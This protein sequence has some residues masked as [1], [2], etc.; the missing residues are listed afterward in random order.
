MSLEDAVRGV[1]ADGQSLPAEFLDYMIQYQSQNSLSNKTKTPNIFNA[2]EYG[3]TGDG[4]TDDT[5]A[6]QAAI[7]DCANNGGGQVYIPAGTYA[8]KTYLTLG[9]NTALVGH[10]PETTLKLVSGYVSGSQGQGHL[11]ATGASHIT[12]DSITFDGNNGTITHDAAN[13]FAV[14]FLNS[15]HCTVKNCSAT[16]IN[17]QGSNLN[18]AFAWVGTSDFGIAADNRIYSCSGGALFF[19]GASSIAHGNIVSTCG[20]VGIVFNSTTCSRCIA[21][22]N[23]IDEIPNQCAFGV[24]AG[25]S[26]FV[27]TSNTIS[28]CFGALDLND[29]GFA[30]PIQRGGVFANNVISD[31]DKGASS[32]TLTLGVFFRSSWLRNVK[33]IGN[34]FSGLHPYGTTDA[35]IYVSANTQDIEI[36]NNT[37]EDTAQSV[38]TGIIFASGTHNRAIVADNIFRSVDTTTK[39]GRGIWLAISTTY[40]NCLITRNRFENITNYG[41]YFDATGLTWS[42]ELRDNKIVSNV[43]TLYF[44]APSSV[45]YG[46]EIGYDQVTSPVLVVSTTSPGTTVIAASAHT[47]DG[48]PVLAEFFC[49]IA[50]SPA[51]A[52]GI[53]N[54]ALFE[55]ATN[56]AQ[57]AQVV[58]PAAANTK[59][60]IL[61]R[62]RFSPSAGSHTYTVSAWVSSTTGTPQLFTG[63]TFSPIFLRFTKI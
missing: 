48:G 43:G 34:Y 3:A 39:M 58:S 6:L 42:G 16:A 32:Q 60:P 53:L 4:V 47:F 20:D 33:I 21:V 30:G 10:G 26:K 29:A 61:T 59:V 41:V 55:G 38:P 57:I 40:V 63:A 37:F 24:E 52:G 54:V 28:R 36:R 7:T 31:L 11:Y 25:A 62:H 45:I 8:L 23:S 51:V 19:Q 44:Q 50:V 15:T 2:R 49:P 35:F 5:N 9:S 27:I 56:I 17:S 13:N 18:T 1:L 46:D 12:V 22:G 14:W